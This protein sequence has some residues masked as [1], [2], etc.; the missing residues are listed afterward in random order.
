M[1]V[2][3]RNFAQKVANRVGRRP[4]PVEV[5]EPPMPVNSDIPDGYISPAD[6]VHI[7]TKTVI[8]INMSVTLSQNHRMAIN[9]LIHA[10]STL[11][12]LKSGIPYKLDD[13]TDIILSHPI[14]KIDVTQITPDRIKDDETKKRAALLTEFCEREAHRHVGTQIKAYRAVCFYTRKGKLVYLT[15]SQHLIPRYSV[16][17]NKNAIRLEVKP[18]IPT[19]VPIAQPV[20]KESPTKICRLAATVV[21]SK[22]EATYR[23][24]P[25]KRIT[26]ETPRTGEQRIR[27][28]EAPFLTLFPTHGYKGQGVYD[29]K[30]FII[31]DDLLAENL[32]SNQIQADLFHFMHMDITAAMKK[33]YVPV[34]RDETAR[35]QLCIDLID[36]ISR[37]HEKGVIHRD[38]K[39]ENVIIHTKG[40][41]IEALPIDFDTSMEKNAPNMAFFGTRGYIAPE[42]DEG[43]KGL[44]SEITDMYSLAHVLKWFFCPA[45]KDAF[46]FFLFMENKDP[47]FKTLDNL[48]KARIEKIINGASHPDPAKRWSMEETRKE[49][50]KLLN[51]LQSKP[52]TAEDTVHGAST[53][54]NPYTL[55]RTTQQDE[56]SFDSSS[57]D[58]DSDSDDEL[59]FSCEGRSA[60]IND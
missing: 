59:Y 9:K 47:R 29:D 39:P 19:L 21:Y 57:S 41:V 4:A 26:K 53:R 23:Q 45:N 13:K 55:F 58:L 43:K 5:Q 15:F 16:G 44:H 46:P 37:I 32:P 2:R 50:Q 7:S 25:Y 6:Q 51:F 10:H 52:E 60:K 40:T 20:T 42:V 48:T 49:F 18:L 56:S 38:I 1:R 31:M 35:I 36:A 17:K 3:F 8:E 33:P 34:I 22:G 24:S 28:D 12:T 30:K 27:L 11:T 54:R 14:I